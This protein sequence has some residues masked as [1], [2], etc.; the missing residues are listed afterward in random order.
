MKDLSI[1]HSQ[2]A[3]A[4]GFGHCSARVI[5]RAR[6]YCPEGRS[7][8]VPARPGGIKI[9]HPF[10]DVEGVWFGCPFMSFG[11]SAMNPSRVSYDQASMKHIAICPPGIIWQKLNLFVAELES[12]S[13]SRD[14]SRGRR[15][16]SA[17]SP[18]PAETAS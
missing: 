3:D 2:S 5:G 6:D 8:L 16:A 9:E 11:A 1:T 13:I 17:G 12:S 18:L 4:P 15:L 14:A 10:V 7:T